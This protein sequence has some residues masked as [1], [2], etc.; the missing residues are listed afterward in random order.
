MAVSMDVIKRVVIQGSSEGLDKVEGDLRKLI[1]TTDGVSVSFEKASR[2]QLSAEAAYKRLSASIDPAAKAQQQIERGTNTL[3]R[4]FQQGA[5]TQDDYNNRLDQL[6]SKY[7]GLAGANDNFVNKNKLARYE[8]IN[9]NRQIQDVGVSLVSGQSPFTVLVQQGSQIYDVFAS[10][11]VTLSGFI[12]Q[13]GAMLTPTRLF[14]AGLVA[15]G[16]GFAVAYS[17]AI[18]YAKSLDDL[19][20]VT[21][22]A[23]AQLEGLQKTADIKGLDRGA[24]S[25]GLKAFTASIDDARFKTNDLRKLFELNGQAIKDNMA[26]N[27]ETVA[28]LI[29]NAETDLDRLRIAQIAGF[30]KSA[31]TLRFFEQIG[32]TGVQA[33][34]GVSS[35]VERDLIQKARAF[36]EAWSTAW[37]EFKTSA[38]SAVVSSLAGLQSLVDKA[39][40]AYLQSSGRELD[41][42]SRIRRGFDATS[43]SVADP[44]L[45]K[46]LEKQA[47]SLRELNGIEQEA[48]TKVNIY[49]KEAKAAHEKAEKAVKEEKEE[50]SLVQT[51]ST[52]FVQSFVGGVIEGKNAVESLGKALSGLGSSLLNSGI[53]DA[54]SDIFSGSSGLITQITG[55]LGIG[56]LGNLLGIGSGLATGGITAL[57]GAGISFLPKLFGGKEQSAREVQKAADDLAK[58]Q[59]N[60]RDMASDFSSWIHDWTTGVSG[61]L[62]SAIESARSQMQQFANA[63]SAAHDPSGVATAQSAF[64]TGVT[65]SINEALDALLNLG[66]ETSSYSQKLKEAKDKAEDIRLTLIEFGT[67][68]ETAALAV[69]TRLTV[70][71][72]RLRG[73]FLDDLVRKVNELAGGAWLN[74]LTDL[75]DEVAQ[76]RADAAALGIQTTLIDEYYVRAAQN[77][78]DQNELVG[79]AF[80]AV[81]ATL[82]PLGAGLHEFS[83]AAEEAAQA[84]KRSAQEIASTIQSYQDQLFIAQQDS[85][86]LSGALAI[87]DLQ[88]QRAREQEIAAG[89]EAL[90]ALE[91]LQAQQRLNIILDFQ[92]RAAEAERQRLEEE[93][94][95]REQAAEQARRALEE[96]QQFLEGAARRISEYISNLLAG[97]QS[98][99]SPA[100]RLAQAQGDFATQKALALG[101]NRDALS[102]ITGYAQNIIDAAKAQYG[103]SAD[104]QTI[105]NDLIAQLQSLPSQVSPEQFIVDNLT[106]PLTDITTSV[107]DQTDAMQTLF[108]NLQSAVNSGSASAIAS[109]LLPVFNS[110]DTN[111]DNALTFAEMQSALGA[112]YSTGTLRSIFTELDG[113]GNGILEKSE[114]IKTATT[115]TGTNTGT[116]STNTA[117]MPQMA[118]NISTINGYSLTT[119]QAT[120]NT[121]AALG[122][123]SGSNYPAT[124]VNVL[125]AINSAGYINGGLLDRIRSNLVEQN[126]NWGDGWT[127]SPATYQNG[128]PITSYGAGGFVDG[129]SHY[130]GGRNINVEGGEYVVNKRD[131]ARFRGM[132]DQINFGHSAP[133]NDNGELISRI[134]ALLAEMKKNT[135]VNAAG[136]EHVREGVDAIAG[137]LAESAR[138]EKLTA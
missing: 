13:I 64:N 59:Q 30:E 67:A 65:R 82:G 136:A 108:A 111:T 27:L 118:N 87:F 10:S 71:I 135:N 17:S 93:R 138:R 116:T 83:A 51:V 79:S 3:N 78:I 49:G 55:S 29:K 62:H 35:A 5:I 68:A 69:E 90:V 100:A 76:L 80:D 89:G 115:T 77:I 14:A 33:V 95:L 38:Q 70:A 94:R 2:S 1:S 107:S 117:N 56:N 132:L 103:S 53:K 81:S 34:A 91:A 6:R 54:I 26:A 126:I 39:T 12:S 112:T 124:L 40:D 9:L 28:K 102:G 130:Y 104:F 45:Q 4:A 84:L 22:I 37:S 7:T 18:N 46:A 57:L 11:R 74:Q 73:Q 72:E 43:S 99:L 36:S 25:S 86:T 32:E 131:T 127:A 23:S 66:V 41:P 96:A 125:S 19:S 133:T 50:I 61:E 92:R 109:A 110:I 63:A 88:A 129:P 128:T 31:D 75:V 121:V 137:A 20:R 106:P 47:A 97:S 16:A 42:T 58:A 21:G 44:A 114:L 24:L 52:N 85:S 48:I 113:N 101:G 98:P 134:N 119:S 8:L 123:T 105:F 120:A 122:G 60:W 15:V